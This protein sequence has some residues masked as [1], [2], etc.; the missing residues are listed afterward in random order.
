[1]SVASLNSL[2]S[3]TLAGVCCLVSTVQSW[4]TFSSCLCDLSRAFTSRHQHRQQRGA[5]QSERKLL[6]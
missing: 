5:T 1:M 3:K 6:A 4:D 2:K